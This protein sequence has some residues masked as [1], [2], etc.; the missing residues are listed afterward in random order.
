[1]KELLRDS[2][3]E[4]IQI[5]MVIG[6]DRG[7]HSIAFLMLVN[8]IDPNCNN[9]MMVEGESL[10]VVLAVD[11]LLRVAGMTD[12]GSL[13]EREASAATMGGKWKGMIN[14]VAVPGGTLMMVAMVFIIVKGGSLKVNISSK[15]I[16]GWSLKLVSSTTWRNAGVIM[17]MTGM[18]MAGATLDLMVEVITT[19]TT[20]MTKI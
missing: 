19:T 10:E 12:I 9:I 13:K 11:K 20:T 7:G 2:G 8:M 6:R 16:I 3:L 5:I 15:T 17:C 14:M 1:M 4:I 18:T